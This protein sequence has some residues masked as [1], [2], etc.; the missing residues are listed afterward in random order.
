MGCTLDSSDHFTP[1]CFSVTIR[2]SQ[3]TNFGYMKP[4]VAEPV[5]VN[6]NYL[7]THHSTVLQLT[8]FKGYVTVE[9]S[10]F[11]KHLIGYEDCG[12]GSVGTMPTDNYAI[13]GTKDKLQLKHVISI[14]EHEHT[15]AIMGNTFQGNT[16]VKGVVYIELEEAQLSNSN[17][18][19]FYKNT[20]AKNAAYFGTSA[21]FVRSKGTNVESHITSDG[22]P[23][24]TGIK[25][26]ENTF[27]NNFG[28]GGAVSGV[29]EF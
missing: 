24:C 21:L 12:A 14:T 8:Q 6:S 9:D 5:F 26:Q 11:E 22:N 16:A 3:F 10:T 4:K 7:M 27:T 19:L 28:C 29:V 25:L 1:P 13:Y 17:P 23:I 18:V 15:I 20:F 2:R